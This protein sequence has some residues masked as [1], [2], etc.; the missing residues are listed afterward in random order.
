MMHV[1]MAS[2]LSA[3]AALILPAFAKA[4]P[5]LTLTAPLIDLD[6]LKASPPRAVFAT[7]RADAANPSELIAQI[8]NAFNEFKGSVDQK[9]AAKVEDSV[10]TAKIDA[11]NADLTRMMKAYDDQSATIAALRIGSGGGGEVSPEAAEHSKAFNTWFRK[12]DRAV[13]DSDMRSLEVKAALTTE[14]DPDGG[15][16]VPSQME[17]GIT[18]VL[19]KVSAI[20]DI[21]RV[22][23]ISGTE[24]KMLVSMGGAKSGWVAERESRSETDTPTLRQIAVEAAEIY[25]N[26][27]I[28]QTALDDAMFDIAAWLADEVSIEFAEQE[29]AAFVSGNGI[30][31]PRGFLDYET[32]A[33]SS[34]SWGK[35]GFVK[36]GAASSFATTA[37]ADAIISLYYALKAGYRNGASF[38][39]SDAAMETIRQMKDGQGNYLW[40]PPTAPEMPMTILGKPVVTDDNMPAIGAN[41]FP[42]AFGNFQRG[43]LI[44]DRI[45][46]RVLRDPYTNKPFVHFYTTKRV[47]GGVQNFEAI[48]L[49]KVS[50]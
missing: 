7:P 14:S 10:L 17:Q 31:K 15:Y 23:S 12:G 26:P 30:K 8:Q 35:L 4:K 48:K 5:S 20:R 44:V 1:R 50:A 11:I 2:L 29:G 6:A 43:Y 46:T 9:L 25:A 40:A 21:S 28:T 32:V 18:R 41:A 34:W 13:Q 45:G 16:L 39:T 22:I 33:N 37:P 42:M 38:V 36:T 3:A 19:G 24:Y 27:A 47:G 49:L